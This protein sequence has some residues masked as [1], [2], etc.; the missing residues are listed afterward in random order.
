MLANRLA[1]IVDVLGSGR[2]WHQLTMINHA[3]YNID[4]VTLILHQL[5]SKTMQ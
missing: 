1:H 3:T 5:T 2:E 4:I